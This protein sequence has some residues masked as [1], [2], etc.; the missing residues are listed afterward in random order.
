M[1]FLRSLLFAKRLSQPSNSHLNG[2]SPIAEGRRGK[3]RIGLGRAAG[4]LLAPTAAPDG[5][6]GLHRKHSQLSKF[7]GAQSPRPSCS[8][9]SYPH[10]RPTLGAHFQMEGGVEHPRTFLFSPLSVS[11]GEF[12][13]QPSPRRCSR[14]LFAALGS[15]R[16]SRRAAISIRSQS[17]L[18]IFTPRSRDILPSAPS[19]VF[20]RSTELGPAGPRHARRPQPHEPSSEQLGAERCGGSAPGPEQRGRLPRRGKVLRP[21]APA[22]LR[23]TIT[24][25]S[26]RLA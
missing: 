16:Q 1:C 23:T 11:R 22:L 10:L 12:Q 25:E 20:F 24:R 14:S 9:L 3:K 21:P 4:S 5:S 13:L 18:A 19:P 8:L 6:T 26:A 17:L 15:E 7:S 2:F